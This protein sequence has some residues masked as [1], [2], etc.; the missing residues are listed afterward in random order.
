MSVE[1]S[2]S[3]TEL[4]NYSSRGGQCGSF[5]LEICDIKKVSFRSSVYFTIFQR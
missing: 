3:V 4:L 1:N 5:T 2:S